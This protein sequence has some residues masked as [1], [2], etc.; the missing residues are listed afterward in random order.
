M[1]EPGF[2]RE[3]ANSKKCH[4]GQERTERLERERIT[5]SSNNVNERDWEKRHI[6]LVLGGLTTAARTTVASADLTQH[7]QGCR[8]PK[9]IQRDY[10]TKQEARLRMCDPGVTYLQTQK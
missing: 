5:N 9:R 1:L 4:Q 2:K 8:H 7:A 10:E 6:L 3:T